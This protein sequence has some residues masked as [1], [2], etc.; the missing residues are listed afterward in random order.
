[1]TPERMSQ[2]TTLVDK[3]DYDAVCVQH[4]E[5]LAAATLLLRCVDTAVYDDSLPSKFTS[6]L[7]NSAINLRTAIAKAQS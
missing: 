1:M 6:N 3:S 2:H 4:D 7:N 5:L